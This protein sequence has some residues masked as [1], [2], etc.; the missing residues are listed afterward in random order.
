MR[1]EE[2]LTARQITDLAKKRFEEER[3]TD[4]L[5]GWFLAREIMRECDERYRDEADSIR[6]AK[7]LYLQ[8][9]RT[10]RSPGR[11]R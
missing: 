3:A 11:T 4:H 2:I 5:E 1:I 8:G 6:S 9:P 10:T 7:T